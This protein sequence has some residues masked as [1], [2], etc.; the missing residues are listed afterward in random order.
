METS[1]IIPD[2]KFPAKPLSRRTRSLASLHRAKKNVAELKHGIVLNLHFDGIQIVDL[3]K[4]LRANSLTEHIRTIDPV[5][6]NA[7]DALNVVEVESTV[8]WI[9]DVTYLTWREFEIMERLSKGWLNKE[10]ADDLGLEYNTVRNNLQRIYPK[11]KV[12]NRSEAILH[13]L[14]IRD[15]LKIISTDQ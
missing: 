2:I 14:K 12:G 9:D 11:F 5:I 15:K 7:T 3:L 4:Y 8:I 10:I 6:E 1:N 13:Y